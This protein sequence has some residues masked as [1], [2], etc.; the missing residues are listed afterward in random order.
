LQIVL[1]NAQRMY[2]ANLRLN[3]P[4]HVAFSEVC[5]LHVILR[6]LLRIFEE[7]DRASHEECMNDLTSSEEAEFRMRLCYTIAERP[8][9]STLRFWIYHNKSKTWTVVNER[10][11]LGPLDTITAKRPKMKIIINLHLLYP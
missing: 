5:H 3:N 2:S 11:F 10:A 7:I 4:L 9:L 6:L 1:L 8:K